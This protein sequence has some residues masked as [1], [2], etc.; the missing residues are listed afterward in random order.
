MEKGFINYFGIH[1]SFK[2]HGSHNHC[3]ESCRKVLAVLVLA[4][5]SVLGSMAQTPLNEEEVYQRLVERQ[6]TDGYREGTPWDNSHTYL[7]TVE[8]FGYPASCFTGAGCFAFMLD[9]MEYASNYE[10]PIRKIEGSYDNL[11][12]IHVG[13]GVR[14]YGN[15]HS[16]VVLEVAEDG[17]TVVVAEGNL[18]SSVHWGRT[19]D[20]AD[21]S[22]D[23][24]YLATFWPEEEE[25]ESVEVT[26]SE[27]EYATFYYSN[28]AY[29]VPEGVEA[30]IVESIDG[31]KLSLRPLDGIIPAECAVILKGAQGTYDFLPTEEEVDAVGDNLLR[32]FDDTH[33]TEGGDIYYKLTVM[34]GKVGFYWG[35]ENGEA[36][37]S[38]PHKA[39]IALPFDQYNEVKFFTFD[40]DNATGIDNI[41]TAT[42]E[43]DGA[44][45]NLSGQR[46]S[47]SYKGVVIINGKK[48]LRK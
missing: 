11:P 15:G 48:V 23:F 30:L 41:E 7:N 19:I 38:G 9:E 14:L 22:N 13:D 31:A 4:T 27:C 43:A 2:S 32:G 6:N 45:Y 10:Y 8:L 24:T 18:N 47:D 35:E 5:V 17:H 39:Y 44:V 21:P 20:L 29:V 37:E 34:N 26:I 28:S 46:V 40:I 16:V 33:L 42:R 25:P 12:K 1:Q 36:F 3:F